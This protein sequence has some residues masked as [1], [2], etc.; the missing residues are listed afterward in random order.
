ML[1]VSQ[2]AIKGATPLGRA[3]GSKQAKAAPPVFQATAG[4][5]PE[6]RAALRNQACFLEILHEEKQRRAAQLV[7]TIRRARGSDKG[8]ARIFTDVIEAQAALHKSER[9]LALMKKALPENQKLDY[10]TVRIG[11]DQR[12]E[13][14]FTSFASE[15]IRHFDGWI[16]EARDSGNEA[17]VAYLKNQKLI[18]L[19]DLDVQREAILEDQCSSGLW[20]RRVETGAWQSAVHSLLW[21]ATRVHLDTIADCAAAAAFMARL[22][23]IAQHRESSISPYNFG[24]LSNRIAQRL[25]K[26]RGK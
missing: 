5:Y 15:I 26:V 16:K 23:K 6:P 22:C 19:Q 12:N 9:A 17:R 11:Y 3:G 21:E 13:P 1:Q 24:P 20:K 8:A 7:R 2:I 4:R 10:P 14:V 18:K 25:A